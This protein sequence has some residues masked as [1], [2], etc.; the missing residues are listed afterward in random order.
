MPLKIPSLK[1]LMKIVILIVLSIGP[2]I[3]SRAQSSPSSPVTTILT[4]LSFPV[5][6]RFA[7]DGRI[8][9]NE[10]NTGNIRIIQQNGTL[11]STPFATISPI[12]TDGESGLLGIA[13]D[14]SFASNRFLYVYYTYRDSQSYT[15][16][17]T[18][19]HTTTGNI[20]TTPTNVLDV[21]SAAPT[22]PPHHNAGYIR[23]GPAGKL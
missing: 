21:V 14:P 8:F 12:Y 22:T 7:P 15:H 4:G 17:P 19:R 16:G 3:F 6:L 20:G 18:V 1:L 11:L 9:F 5:S 23:S 2:W 13:L 10:K